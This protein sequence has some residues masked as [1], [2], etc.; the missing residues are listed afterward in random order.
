MNTGGRPYNPENDALLD[1]RKCREVTE[2]RE[3]HASI[4]RGFFKHKCRTCGTERK[5]TTSAL[6]R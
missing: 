1:C 5:S 3:T 2:H 6:G 4:T